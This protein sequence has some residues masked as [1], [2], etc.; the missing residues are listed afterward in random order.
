M[1]G[2]DK[3]AS[4]LVKEVNTCAP[5]LQHVEHN[6]KVEIALSQCMPCLRCSQHLHC[7]G[8]VIL[9][10]LCLQ[11]FKR[12]FAWTH[13]SANIHKVSNMLYVHNAHGIDGTAWKW[14]THLSLNALVKSVFAMSCSAAAAEKAAQYS[15]T[16]R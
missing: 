8:I 15:K 7:T 13:T 3:Q 16:T 1:I 2:P 6:T 14:V 11:T 9:T 12:F 10:V 5:P 4:S